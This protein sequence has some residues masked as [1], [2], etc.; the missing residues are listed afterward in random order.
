MPGLPNHIF[1]IGDCFMIGVLYPI[2]YDFE[3]PRY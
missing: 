1:R 2:I 3:K